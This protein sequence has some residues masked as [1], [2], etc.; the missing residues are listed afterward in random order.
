MLKERKERE[1]TRDNGLD[2][3]PPQPPDRPKAAV[4]TEA[5]PEDVTKRET[6]SERAEL[7]AERGIPAVP[8]EKSAGFHQV[9]SVGNQWKKARRQR[10]AR[11]AARKGT[12]RFL[13][14]RQLGLG[15]SSY[16]L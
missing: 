1:E 16:P 12:N 2:N 7:K 11:K 4:S 15:I 10:K 8:L 13:A 3:L 14:V 9:G 5:V 6:K